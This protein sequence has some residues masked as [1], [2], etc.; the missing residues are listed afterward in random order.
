[1]IEDFVSIHT[2]IDRIGIRY[3]KHGC[4]LELCL[5]D[6]RTF[7]FSGILKTPVAEDLQKNNVI[8]RLIQNQTTQEPLVIKELPYA[9]KRKQNFSFDGLWFCGSSNRFVT[10]KDRIGTIYDENGKDLGYDK[11]EIDDR[12]FAGIQTGFLDYCWNGNE[13]FVKGTTIPWP[14]G[15]DF[16]SYAPTK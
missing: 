3:D 6:K 8:S 1:M 2:F 16:D 12:G 4:S 7:I 10:V 15:K 11:V 14:R 5:P 9:I 13:Q